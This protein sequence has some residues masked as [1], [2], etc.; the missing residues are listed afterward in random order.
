MLEDPAARPLER[1]H[2]KSLPLRQVKARAQQITVD[3][4]AGLPVGV[5]GRR[6][7]PV[8][9]LETLKEIGK[10]HGIGRVDLVESRF[11]GMKSRGVYETPGGSILVAAHQD[12]EALTVGRDL[13]HLKNTLA[14][15]FAQM[16]YF[17]F[18][19]CEEMEALQSF[20][21]VSQR[22]V[23]GRVRLELDRGNIS[24][25]GRESAHSLYDAAIA[26]MESD[27]GAYDQSDA[28]G[29]IGLQALPCGS[30]RGAWPSWPRRRR[31]RVY[32]APARP[33]RPARAARPAHRAASSWRRRPET[34]APGHRPLTPQ[35]PEPPVRPWSITT[36]SPSSSSL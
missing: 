24:I 22:H 36:H 31:R 35:R 23:T 17:G 9:L 18:W 5:N 33:A 32:V 3:F 19:Y 30:R 2:Q 34:G 27:G 16:V 10:G 28:S 7:A 4:V 26:S 8:K 29:F 21:A 15:R 1:M 14:V 13:L 25:I 6:M 11:V 20:L 12:L